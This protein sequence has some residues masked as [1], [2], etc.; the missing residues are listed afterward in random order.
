M[1]RV[2]Q[3]DGAAAAAKPA[4][5][6]EYG[7][8]DE[9]AIVT[10]FAAAVAGTASGGVEGVGRE[11]DVAD[12]AGPVAGRRAAAGETLNSHGSSRYCGI[13]RKK[14]LVWCN[15]DPF[16]YNIE[17]EK[18]IHIYRIGQGLLFVHI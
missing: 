10:E 5:G 15:M 16:A 17:R 11:G 3:C 7:R 2:L 6:V 8:G 14:C 1:E 18:E 12:A 4:Y 13:E 9:G